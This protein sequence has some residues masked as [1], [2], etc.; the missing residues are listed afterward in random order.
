[1]RRIRL[2]IEEAITLKECMLGSQDARQ[3][4]RCHALLL[5]HKGYTIN[6]LADIFD[7]DRDT[8]SNWFERWQS[9]GLEGLSDAVR[10]GRPPKLNEVQKKS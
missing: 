6:Q 1:M 3:I 5:S 8:I 4:N 7:V 10:S 2:S 9:K